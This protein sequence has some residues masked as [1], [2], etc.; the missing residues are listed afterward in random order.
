MKTTRK[1]KMA[2]RDVELARR[3]SLVTIEID[4]E[5]KITLSLKEELLNPLRLGGRISVIGPSGVL[6]ESLLMEVGIGPS[7]PYNAGWMPADNSHKRWWFPERK[8]FFEITEEQYRV[9]APLIFCFIQFFADRRVSRWK[10]NHNNPY[11]VKIMR[12]WWS[13]RKKRFFNRE[14]VVNVKLATRFSVSTKD[15][16]IL[17]DV[18]LAELGFNESLRIKLGRLARFVDKR[19]KRCRSEYKGKKDFCK[20]KASQDIREAAD[21]L[22]NYHMIEMFN[23]LPYGRKNVFYRHLAKLF[24]WDEIDKT[25]ERKFADSA[26][27]GSEKRFGKMQLQ[28]V[29]MKDK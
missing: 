24:K 8:N 15:N 7:R 4:R 22:P 28:V 3:I 16:F 26:L 9:V 23:H 29:S 1:E 19:L 20:L 12:R 27:F 6:D 18:F 21:R 10:C 2:R 17:S 11:S 25:A 14:E 5:A 13:H